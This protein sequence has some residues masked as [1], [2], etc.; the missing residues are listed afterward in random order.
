MLGPFL[1][2]GSLDMRMDGLEIRVLLDILADGGN[3]CLGGI[4]GITDN[5]YPIV[6]I[7][8]YKL[9]RPADNGLLGL[10]VSPGRED[11]AVSLLPAA[12]VYVPVYI[13][14]DFSLADAVALLV[15]QDKLTEIV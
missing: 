10:T 9:Q 4:A 11:A 3:A 15:L 5:E 14:V 8:A 2:I 13:F 7:L 12:F 1:F 6:R